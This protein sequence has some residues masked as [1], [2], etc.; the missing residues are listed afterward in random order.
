MTAHRV[1]LVLVGL[2]LGVLMLAGSATPLPPT[3]QPSCSPGPTDC[4]AWHTSDV[5]VSWSGGVC[6]PVTITS[7]TGGTP[8]SCTVTDGSGS[9]TVSVIVRR[10]A[11]P[12]GVTASPDRGPD[13]NGWYN[14]GLSVSF[15]GDDGLSGVASCTSA[16]SYGGPDT[17]G[18]SISGSCTDWA[19]NTGRASIEIKYDGTPPTVEAKPDRGPNARGWYNRE[20]TVAFLGTDATSGVDSCTPPI[21]YKGPDAAKAS[22]SGTCQDKAAN[23]SPP[24]GFELGYDTKPP[25][26]GRVKAE[27]A[28]RGISLRWTA[29]KD[30]LSFEIVRRPGLRGRKATTLYNGKAR[31][32]TD[33][34]LTKGVKYRYTVTAYD[35][36]G[37][38]AAKGLAARAESSVAKPS[39][40]KPQATKPQAAKP[41]LTQPAAGARV[42]A[43]PLLA[44]RAVP[45]A[46]YYN[47]QLFRNG[48]KILTAWPNGPSFR[49][50][51]SWTFEGRTYRLTPGRYRW[52][53]WP[54]FGKRSET[55]YGAL[56][57]TRRFVVTRG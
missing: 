11:S 17:G 53:V 29:S 49:L 2:T 31:S 30:A 39:A 14:H 8:V 37:N 52:Y 18:V 55:R 32:F 56:V 22:V 1:G 6:S 35:E 33:R 10:D 26:L 41:A 25:S 45:R 54:G 47:V 34:Q 46:T 36:A 28:P 20:V 4:G 48:R 16:S 13:N 21:T 38:G 44:W 40:T 42:S 5:T 9:I 24:R 50:Q 3:P 27:V 7:D 57:G 23:T 43:P 12:P 15:S 19:G 51:R